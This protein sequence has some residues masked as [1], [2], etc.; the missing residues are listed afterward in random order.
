MYSLCRLSHRLIVCQKSFKYIR[1][2]STFKPKEEMK[3]TVNYNVID[4]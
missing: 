3:Q 2:L 4:I 1:Y